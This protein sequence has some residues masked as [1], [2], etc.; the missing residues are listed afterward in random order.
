MSVIN[1]SPRR[2]NVSFKLVGDEGVQIGTT[3]VLPIEPL[4]K[5]HIDDPD[6]FLNSGDELRQGYVVVSSDGVRLTGSVVFGNPTATFSAALPL[7][8]RLRGNMVFGQV[9]SNETFFTGLA[10]F[11][12]DEGS[13]RAVLQVFDNTGKAVASKIETIPAK[14]R[15]NQLLTEYFPELAG[16]N[17][18]SGYIKITSV[19]GLA[20][21]AIFGANNLS[22]LSAVPAQ[23]VP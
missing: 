15:K 10:I 23:V 4:G 12:P 19:R 7:V 16:R 9:A 2:G 3:Q 17:L 11:N 5:I 22:V 8:S 21:F 6:F 13:A 18:S 14:G 20:A 1:L